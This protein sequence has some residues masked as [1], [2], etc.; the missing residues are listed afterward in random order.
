MLN[1]TSLTPFLVTPFWGCPSKVAVSLL[2][3]LMNRTLVVRLLWA[4]QLVGLAALVLWTAADPALPTLLDRL[5]NVPVTGLSE[6]EWQVQFGQLRMVLVGVLGS[7]VACG[8][9]GILIGML[10]RSAERSSLKSLRGLIALTAIVALWCS[11]SIHRETVAW[12]GKRL[13]IAWKIGELETLAQPLRTSF[14]T[15]DGELPRIGPFMAYPFGTPTVLIL[16]KPP[17]LSGGELCVGAVQRGEQGDIKF[18]LTGP[19]GGD[20]AEWHPDSSQPRSFVGGLGDHHR[21]VTS[22]RLGNGWY[23]VRYHDSA[24]FHDPVD[25]DLEALAQAEPAKA[26]EIG[27]LRQL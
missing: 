6:T 8:F 14:P 5:I 16:L 1:I 15:T 11:F 7:V 12:Q 18:Q 20:W 27:Y 10:G 13:R 26:A 23:L 24:G 25:L 9:A 3:L 4:S 19:D 17:S 22:L 21:L 2:I